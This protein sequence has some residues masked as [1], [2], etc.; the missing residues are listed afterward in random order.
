MSINA[1]QRKAA[2]EGKVRLRLRYP[3]LRQ[4]K[5]LVKDHAY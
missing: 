5:N 2:D 1:K 4:F 3:P